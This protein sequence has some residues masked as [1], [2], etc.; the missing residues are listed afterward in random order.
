MKKTYDCTASR[1]FT[2]SPQILKDKRGIIEVQLNDD[3][4]QD[5]NFKKGTKVKVIID[6]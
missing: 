2:L 6:Y 3:K 1:R 5:L 4:E